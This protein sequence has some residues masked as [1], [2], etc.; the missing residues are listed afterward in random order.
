MTAK[1]LLFADSAHERLVKGM[2]TLAEAVRVTLGP[3]ARTVV[4]EKSWGA[5]TVINSGVVVAKEIEL[6]DRFENMG[7]QMVREV[8]AKT[9]EVAGDGTTTATLLAAAIV[10]EGM[11]YVAAGM[12]PMDLKRGIDLAVEKLISELERMAKP[13]STRNEI[14]QVGS[15]SANNDASIG[16]MIA[17]AMEKVGR[18]G[19][20]TVEDGKGLANEL[21]VVEGTQ[22]DRGFL[23]PYF[24]TNAEKQSVVLEDAYILLYDKKI[25]TIRELLPLLEHVAKMGKPMLVI[26]EE[27]EGEALAT[28]VVNKLR[29]VLHS[30]AVK[31]PGFGDRRK[32]MLE[33]L[34]VLT[35]GAVVAEEAG[36]TLEK[37][38]PSVL[39]RARRV[40]IDK[41]DTTIIGGAG[42]RKA[43]D[44]RV[45]Q[46][47]R[48]I[49]DS[50]SDYDKEKLQ[51]RAAKLAGGVALI[52]VGA[53]TETEMKER[54]SRTED[55]LHATR[56][57]VE[58]GVLAG[59]GV[60]LLRA[61]VALKALHGKNADQDAGVRIVER[62]VEEPLRQIVRNAG[63]E[64]AV[65]VQRVLDGAG[66]FG[67]NAATG[68]YGDLVA[69]GVLDPRKVTRAALQNAASIASLILTTDCMI[70]QAPEKPAAPR[71][72]D[73]T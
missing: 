54:K 14:A 4:L 72:E 60:A 33:D 18:E 29:G 37:A 71:D 40:E 5:P 17:E 67:Y 19:V 66:N 7:A 11:K 31:A 21:E 38:D 35:G 1:Q 55:A 39:G 27:V 16:N 15:I 68:E 58:E 13:C 6:E 8:A 59:G 69:M 41:D 22:F 26:A 73:M 43:I 64:P 34:A 53:A 62:A 49:E 44:A 65:V 61:R 63:E 36:I 48:E 9:S 25:S 30:C 45:A 10:N 20:I 3:K 50:T 2:N 56:A 47:K 28:L 24:I 57:A 32:A 12:N 46:I 23:S 42:E 51:E 52:R 70:A